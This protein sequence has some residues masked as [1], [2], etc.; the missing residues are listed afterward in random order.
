MAFQQLP[1]GI[2][3]LIPQIRGSPIFATVERIFQPVT[4]F[5]RG[6]PIVSTAAIGAGTTGLIAGIAGVRARRKKPRRKAKR[7]KAPTRKRVKRRKVSRK[8][9]AKR[10]RTKAELREFRCRCLA[11]ARR[12][13]KKRTGI[14]R[15]RGLGPREIRHSGK[16]TKGKFKLV[17]FKDKR[18]GK[19]V[20]FKARK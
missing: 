10:K 3:Q 19:M 6:N 16:S 2:S 5:I 8:P 7:K 4:D 17:S 12:A 13:R 11:K 18:T 14:K 9:R 15:G 1:T 20:R